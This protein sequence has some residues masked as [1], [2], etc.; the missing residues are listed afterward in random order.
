MV[1]LLHIQILHAQH[2]ILM[3]VVAERHGETVRSRSHH[4]QGEVGIVTMD[5]E[6]QRRFDLI[7]SDGEIGVV[8]IDPFLQIDLGILWTVVRHGNDHHIRNFY[9]KFQ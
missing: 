2:R 5:P 1:H 6:E 9:R 8:G 3:N 7:P 4:P